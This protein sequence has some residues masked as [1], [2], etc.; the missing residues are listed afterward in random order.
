MGVRVLPA[1]FFLWPFLNLEAQV[2]LGVFAGPQLSSARYL[3]MNVKQPVQEK[4][5]FMAG[6]AAKVDFESNFYFF[7]ALYY[8]LRGYKVTLNKPSYPPTELAKNNNTTLHT[9]QIAPLFNVDLSKKSSPIFVRFGP[10][11]NITLSGKER[12]DTAAN[13]GTV[14][15]GLK[16]AVTDYG[17]ITASANVQLG[18][19]TKEGLMIFLHYEYGLGSMSNADGGP[20]IL[21]RVFGMAAGWFLKHNPKILRSHPHRYR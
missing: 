14:E 7:P 13:G 2:R 12:F 16:F 10:S 17:R 8:S 11:L 3:I 15:R 20:I 18:Y 1:L 4:F 6:G 5:G 9:L 19:Q 21:H